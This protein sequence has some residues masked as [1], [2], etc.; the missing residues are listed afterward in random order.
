VR[1]IVEHQV[2]VNFIGDKDESVTAAE[3]GKP[4]QCGSWKNSADGIVGIA[5][6][7]KFGVLRDGSLQSIEID[8]P[9]AVVFD[10]IHGFQTHSRK[11]W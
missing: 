2:A 10:Q 8:L 1:Q 6:N 4:L 7:E 11:F 9:D 3:I 5:K